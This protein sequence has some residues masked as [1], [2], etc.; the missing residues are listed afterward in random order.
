MTPSARRRRRRGP[1][2]LGLDPSPYPI[3]DYTNNTELDHQ[4]SCVVVFRSADAMRHVDVIR[5]QHHAGR[6]GYIE[7]EFIRLLAIRF[8][9]TADGQA[10]AARI[11]LQLLNFPFRSPLFLDH[12]GVFLLHH[13]HLHV[14]L[15]DLAVEGL[16][17]CRFH[18]ALSHLICKV[19]FQEKLA[20][21]LFCAL[22][23][24]VCWLNRHLYLQHVCNIKLYEFRLTSPAT[25]PHSPL[26]TAHACRTQSPPPSRSGDPV[27]AEGSGRTSVPGDG[28]NRTD[29]THVICIARVPY[30]GASALQVWGLC[31]LPCAAYPNVSPAQLWLIPLTTL[32][33]PL[34]CGRR[35]L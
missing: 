25:R 1:L 6:F 5:C 13:L 34:P 33:P 32:A 24:L 2:A 16:I 35:C 18:D 14:H 28:Q 15:L 8:R 9:D 20:N 22:H 17:Y 29:F 12:S 10:I 30:Q 7:H 3:Y 19:R 27:T 21:R 26:V 31:N 23:C 4:V 11:R